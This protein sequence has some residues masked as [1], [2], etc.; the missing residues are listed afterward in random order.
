MLTNK[1]D[2]LIFVERKNKKI[3]FL[4]LKQKK[5]VFNNY[6]SNS[7]MVSELCVDKKFQRRGLGEKILNKSQEIIY[8]E[9]APG[10]LLSNKKYEKF[11]SQR[12]WVISKDIYIMEKNNSNQ[13]KLDDTKICFFYNLK[14]Y[15]KKITLL[16]KIF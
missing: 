14:D 2:K 7:Y 12:G 10:Y 3:G 16:G 8:M 6:I 9:K 1:E 15:S 13:K 4:R 5:I 11:Y